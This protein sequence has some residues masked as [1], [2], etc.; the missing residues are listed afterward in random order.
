MATGYYEK[1]PAQK[2]FKGI[3]FTNKSGWG[4]P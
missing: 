1:L 4:N 2:T 3:N